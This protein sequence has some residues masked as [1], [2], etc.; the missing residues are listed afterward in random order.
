MSLSRS[1]QDIFLAKGKKSTAVNAKRIV[2]SAIG[3]TVCTPSFMIGACIAH[4]MVTIRVSNKSLRV[5]DI[6]FQALSVRFFNLAE[7]ND[8]D[9]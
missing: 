2:L 4:K 6:I 9:P 1:L 3:S 8:A 7:G 5:R